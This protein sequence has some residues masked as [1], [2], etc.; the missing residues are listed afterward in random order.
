MV[1]A[2]TITHASSVSAQ[3]PRPAPNVSV[4]TVPTLPVVFTPPLLHV[5]RG[6]IGVG[7]DV[8]VLEPARGPADL[9]VRIVRTVEGA[10]AAVVGIVPGD[11][12]LAID[13]E[14]LTIESWEGFTQNLR[15]GVEVRLAL[16]RGGFRREVRL[17]TT[18]RPSLAPVP[19]GLATHLDSVRTAFRVQFESN[20]D[21]WSS[22]DYVTLLTAGDSWEE[23]STRILDRVRQNVVAFGVRPENTVN[24]LTPSRQAGNRY[25]VVWNTHGVLPFEYLML[26]SPAADS[27]KT[28][29]IQ[30]RGELNRVA[31]AARNREQEIRFTLRTS[32]LGDNDERLLSLR[33]DNE[34]VRE[35]LEQLAFRLAEIGSTER[36]TRREGSVRA[37]GA[38]VDLTANIRPVTARIVGQNFV[39]GAQFNDLNPQLGAYFGTDRGVL[40]IQVMNGTP[41]DD[42]GLIPGDVVTHVAGTEI[43]SVEAFRTALNGVF[44]RR[45]QAE[46]TLLRRGQRMTATLSR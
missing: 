34:R 13:G 8:T 36:E 14:L 19:T 43:A 27:V 15:P 45:R 10:P 4:P 44:A 3:V 42:A 37:E 24:I 9:E 2:A 33:L 17:T 23:A 7:V 12:I 20:R 11:V 32:G 16:D 21:R 35:D 28:A 30:M 38:G 25:S 39:G 6:W 26:Q 18:P 1:A 31:E 22:R 29:M 46:L 5:E 41:C 40:V